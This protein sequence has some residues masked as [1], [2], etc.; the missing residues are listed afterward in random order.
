MGEIKK[1]NFNSLFNTN[2]LIAQ[3]IKTEILNNKNL[4]FYL[5]INANNIKNYENFKNI[6]LNL[7]IQDSL[8]DLDNTKFS[9]KDYV[10]FQISDSLLFVKDNELI[11]DA[12]LDMTIKNSSQI[13]KSLLTPKN[14]RTELKKIELSLS[15]NFDQKLL[16]FSNIKINNQIDKDLNK[17][18]KNL[19]FKDDELQNKIYFKNE[20]NKAIKVYSG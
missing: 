7:K 10:D 8:I 2:A 16:K 3:M 6:F 13:Y 12:Y 18:L 11:I 9:W 4:D 5:N 15:Y 14:Y 20:M 17:Y 1:I 19:I